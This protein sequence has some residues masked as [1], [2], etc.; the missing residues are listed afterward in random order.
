MKVRQSDFGRESYWQACIAA[1]LGEKERAMTLLHDAYTQ[2]R[3]FTIWL[4]RDMD[5]E[6]LRDYPPFQELLRPKG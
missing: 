6:P 4:H 3:A 1:L 2:G 5:L